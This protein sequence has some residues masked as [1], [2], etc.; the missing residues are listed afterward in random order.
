MSITDYHSMFKFTTINYDPSVLKRN[1]FLRLDDDGTGAEKT[2]KGGLVHT[3]TVN[4]PVDQ[5]IWVVV[6]TWDDRAIPDKCVDKS[7]RHGLIP[8]W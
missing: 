7:E 3:L 8:Q 2:D 4:S 6:N 5:T 1:H